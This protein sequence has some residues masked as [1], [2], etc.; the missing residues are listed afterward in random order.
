MTMEW[1][2]LYVPKIYLKSNNNNKFLNSTPLT[3]NLKTKFTITNTHI[4]IQ[5]HTQAHMH[6]AKILLN[7]NYT[8]IHTHIYKSTLAHY[9]T[10]IITKYKHKLTHVSVNIQHHIEGKRRKA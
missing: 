5:Q 1:E 8:N 4:I 10:A 3:P 6:I 9:H 7:T 2:E